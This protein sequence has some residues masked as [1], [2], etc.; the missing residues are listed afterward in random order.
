MRRDTIILLPE[1]TPAELLLKAHEADPDILFFATQ[2]GNDCIG[3]HYI[4]KFQ[5]RDPDTYQRTSKTVVRSISIPNNGENYSDDV[6]KKLIEEQI[7]QPPLPINSSFE[8]HN[9]QQKLHWK[10]ATCKTFQATHEALTAHAI[11]EKNHR[12]FRRN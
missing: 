5:I 4:Q 11:S 12:I 8:W 9:N 10:I 3:I 6:L 7:I 1:E 2:K